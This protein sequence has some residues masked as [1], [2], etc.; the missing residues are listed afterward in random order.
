MRLVL[1][2]VLL[3]F[4]AGLGFVAWRAVEPPHA[5]ATPQPRTVRLLVATRPL[6]PGT[7]LKDT[8][9][10]GEDVPLAEASPAMLREGAEDRVELR[11]ALLRRYLE[12]GGR[13]Q[14]DDMLRPR[15][16]G[17]LAAVLRPDSRAISIG[18]DA[19][20]GTAGLIWPGDQVD[21]IL[22]QQL[23]A[24]QAP[25]AQRVVAETILTDV[26][27]I[28]VDQQIAQGAASSEGAARS[29][30]RTVTLEVSGQQA[31]RVAIAGRLGRLSLTVRAMEAAPDVPGLLSSGISGA[32]VSAA[33]SRSNRTGSRMRVIQGNETQEMSFQ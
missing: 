30:A 1:V 31:E 21:L 29:V 11:G 28:A 22:T 7:L 19:V 16:R 6:A 26:R 8:D 20:T 18:V 12:A 10:R 9:V 5:E 27:V 32:D 4:A 14:R 25:V 23:D 3:L 2:L 33:L 24:A 15:D 17:F 13:L